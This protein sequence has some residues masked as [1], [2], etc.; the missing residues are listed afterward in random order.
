MDFGCEEG[1]AVKK[2]PGLERI[3]LWSETEKSFFTET[4]PG[5]WSHRIESA[6][7]LVGP[8]L[9]GMI[10]GLFKRKVPNFYKEVIIRRKE[11]L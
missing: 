6:C 9:C 2:T 8:F 4:R 10:Y 11:T 1:G 7:S 3:Y 5:I